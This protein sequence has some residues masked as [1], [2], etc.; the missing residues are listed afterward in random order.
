MSQK[1]III[2]IGREYGSGGHEIGEKLAKKLGFA[3]YDKNLIDVTAE[4]NGL[5]IEF[6]HAVDEK[7]PGIFAGASSAINMNDRLFSA[8]FK[9]LKELAD[10]GS[11]VVVGRCSDYVLANN[12]NAVHIFI[13]APL[14]DRVARIMERHLIYDEDE[15]R[16]VIR[17]ED[18][19]R[20]TYY[21]YYAERKWG[22]REGKTLIIDSSFLGID[23]TVDYIADL[24]SRK[25]PEEA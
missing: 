15:A 1:N 7:V 6:S 23:G 25:W 19:R 5:D 9:V 4:K 3:F 24:V 18:K 21:Q 10:E 16:K 22:T 13:T 20:R 17:T 14:K 8:Q 12:P 2:T 11:A